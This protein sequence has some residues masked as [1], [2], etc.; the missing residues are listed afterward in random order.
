MNTLDII[1][2]NIIFVGIVQ[3]TIIFQKL[4]AMNVPKFGEDKNVNVLKGLLQNKL[5]LFGISLNVVTIAYS[6]FLFSISSI[7]FIMVFQR[8]G[9]IV[10][11]LFA[12][13]YLKESITKLEITGLVLVYVGFFMMLS[14]VLNPQ[15]TNVYT[16]D[17]GILIFFIF[18]IS[19]EIFTLLTY[20]RIKIVKIKEILIAIGAGVSGAAGTIA[21]KIIPMALARDLGNPNYIFN[22]IDIPELIN[23]LAGI[24]LPGTPYFFGSLYYYL[25]MGNFIM[26]FFL[27]MMMYQHGRA[28]VTI[29]INTNIQFI[30]SIFFGYLVFSEIIDI[31]SWFG[32]AMMV[33]G[34]ILTS[35]VEKQ[36]VNDQTGDELGIEEKNREEKSEV[37]GALE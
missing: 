37:N 12:F 5:W 8:L 15:T 6:T 34:I 26:N 7:S 32:V 13:L 1:L 11:F 10:T 20:N 27:T 4:G 29:P 31:L 33:I 17:A 24:F 16:S 22:L 28:G 23:V 3:G 2:Y 21:L 30:I 18:P 36:L 9:V 25:W 19:I 35:K 14:I